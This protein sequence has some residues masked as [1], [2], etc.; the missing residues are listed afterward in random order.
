MESFTTEERSR[1][2]YRLTPR[3]LKEIHE[4]MHQRITLAQAHEHIDNLLVLMRIIE[5]VQR[6]LVLLTASSK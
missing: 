4:I 2:K 6:R 1:V 3:F 5:A